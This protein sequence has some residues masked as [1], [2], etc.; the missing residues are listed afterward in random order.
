[1]LLLKGNRRTATA[2][3]MEQCIRISSTLREVANYATQPCWNRFY[4]LSRLELPLL[5][6]ERRVQKFNI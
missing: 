2:R 5:S 3:S 4:Q 1:M 6:Y